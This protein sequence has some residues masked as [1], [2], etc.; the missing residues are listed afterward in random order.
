MIT[1]LSELEDTLSYLQATGFPPTALFAPSPAM[2]KTFGHYPFLSHLAANA[3]AYLGSPSE[4]CISEIGGCLFAI[5]PFREY[6]LALGPFPNRAIDEENMTDLAERLALDE[7][8]KR[9]VSDF[10]HSTP[11]LSLNWFLSSIGL[12]RF[13]LTGEKESV[14]SY[15]SATQ[16][17]LERQIGESYSAQILK[18]ENIIHA[19]YGLEQRLLHYVEEGD[20]EELEALINEIARSSPIPEGKV[21]GD[22]LRQ[23]KNI[24][25]AFV[26]IIG[27]IGA[28][29]GGLEIEE[30]YRLI[31]IYT[32][33]C[34]K[35]QNVD[36]VN[37][38]RYSALLDFTNRVK[39]KRQPQNY[40]PSVSQAI[41]YIKSHLNE[42]LQV[43]DVIAE[44]GQSRSAFMAKFKKE[45]GFSL[46][47]FVVESRLQEA[48]TLLS[49]TDM[50]L[51]EI[52]SFFYF[53]SQSHFQ[54]L[55]K[56]RFGETPLQYRNNT[57]KIN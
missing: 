50:P 32:Q 18:E 26:A 48:K 47:Q 51:A 6:H 14:V 1:S 43:E 42:P 27:K 9:A 24:F 45:T 33:E 41:H 2:T 17:K 55:F 52:A 8:E 31:D 30:T 29:N 53:S 20:I 4:P 34:E 28:I 11:H 35:A 38:L 7:K 40:S 19:T 23:S 49:Y 13:L 36:A 25:I 44:T 15:F 16:P 5:L 56:K 39:N 57:R 12:L 54:N 37:K 21:A 3:F 22:F 10:L 46:W